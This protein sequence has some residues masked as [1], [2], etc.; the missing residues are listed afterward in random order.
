MC[1]VTSKTSEETQTDTGNCFLHFDL[2]DLTLGVIFKFS[3]FQ[4]EHYS[5]SF[6]CASMCFQLPLFFL[7]IVF[8]QRTVQNILLVDLNLRLI[9]LLFIITMGL[10]IIIIVKG[11]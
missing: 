4:F 6:N 5:T 9:R 3:I 8:S 11:F 1:S 10:D 2:S 7:Q